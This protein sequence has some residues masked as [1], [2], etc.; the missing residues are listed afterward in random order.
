METSLVRH[1]LCCPL[2][3]QT[4]TQQLN[5]NKA[6][7]PVSAVGYTWWPRTTVTAMGPA[8]LG[9][10]HNN[11]DNSSSCRYLWRRRRQQQ[12]Q[13]RE[14]QRHQRLDASGDDALPLAAA[15]CLGCGCGLGAC[16][17]LAGLGLVCLDLLGTLLHLTDGLVAV[18][19]AEL[20]GRKHR[21][22]ATG[23]QG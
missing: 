5:T 10:H 18:G 6:M 8:L 23:Q 4:H 20:W 13:L 12:Q 19:L 15:D 14:Q 9:Q 3:F 11:L 2:P 22:R 7:E 16:C 17:L 21:H 1:I